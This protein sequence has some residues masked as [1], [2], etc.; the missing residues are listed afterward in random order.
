ML[1]IR[2]NNTA[3]LKVW[4][5]EEAVMLIGEADFVRF[6]AAFIAQ[7]TNASHDESLSWNTLTGVG[8]CGY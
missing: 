4:V 5:L 3:F 1:A 2:Q 6:V 7:F 8:V